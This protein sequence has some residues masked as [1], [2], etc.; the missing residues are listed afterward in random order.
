MTSV[1]IF[2][3]STS[4]WSPWFS[5]KRDVSVSRG[6]IVTR[7]LSFESAAV[8]LRLLGKDRSGLKPWQK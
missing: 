2:E 5:Q 6:S 1:W 4:L 7:N 8:I 3:G